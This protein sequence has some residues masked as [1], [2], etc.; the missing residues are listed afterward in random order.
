MRTRSS[1]DSGVDGDPCDCFALEAEVGRAVVTDVD[2]ED[3]GI[4]G[5]QAERDLVTRPRALDVQR[6]TLERGPLD[7]VGRRARARGHHCA[8]QHEDGNREQPAEA[9]TIDLFF[10]FMASFR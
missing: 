7:L 3:A 5:L 9:Q 4:A 2:L 8:R 6:A 10:V 1:P